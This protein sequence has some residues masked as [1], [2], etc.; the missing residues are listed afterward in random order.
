MKNTQAPLSPGI[1]SVLPLFYVAWS[2]GIL[3][4][5][6]MKTLHRRLKDFDFLSGPDRDY[7]KK[8]TDPTK[9]PS[10]EI[11]KSWVNQIRLY[12][13]DLPQGSKQD[14]VQL[15]IDMAMAAAP[16]DL[17]SRWLSQD[18]LA[19]LREIKDQLGVEAVAGAK[20]LFA[21]ADQDAEL[22]PHDPSKDSL[23]GNL[24]SFLE[25]DSRSFKD[26]LRALFS[27]PELF[28]EYQGDK[29][30]HRELVLDQMRILA[31]QGY[32]LLPYPEDCGGRDD[33]ERY[34]QVF[35][36]L[37][38]YDGSLVVK[39][40]VQFGLY[41]LSIKNLGT[42]E[43]HKKYLNDAGILK[44]LGCFA[45]TETGHGSNVRGL[46][47]TASYDRASDLIVVHTPDR[48]SAKEYIGN[49]LHGDMAV[50][51]A[52][53]IVN[54][55]NHGVHAVVVP[56]REDNGQDVQGV[57]REDCGYKMGLNG[58][59]NGRLYFDQVAVPRSNLLSRFGAISDDGEY[60]SRIENPNKRFFTMLGTLVGGRIGVAKGALSM[61]KNALTIALRY[62]ERRRQFGPA[63]DR[64][65]ALLM[66]YPSHQM[67]LLP[68][69]VKAYGLQ[70]ATDQLVEEYR[71]ST[72]SS[73]K[74]ETKAAGL[75]ACATWFATDTIQECREAC[76]GAGYIWE[77]GL[78]Q[79]KADSD[80]FTTFEG[81]NT[82]LMQLVAKGLLSEF[83]KSFHDEG[84][85]AVF[86]HLSQRVT[87]S[88]TEKNVFQVRKTDS[89][90]LLSPEFHREAFRFREKHLLR[91]VGQRMKKYLGK[92]VSLYE[93]F[94]RCQNHMIALAQAYVDRLILKSLHVARDRADGEIKELLILCAEVYALHSIYE[95][96]AYFLEHGY[97]EPTKTKAVLRVL[98]QRLKKIRPK[99]P[100]LV[101][102]WAIPE[103]C[104]RTEIS[105]KVDRG[106]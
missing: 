23:R 42:E 106:Y 87:T 47:T 72:S 62:A 25:G 53:L 1:L 65:Q 80:I 96:R 58:V 105:S 29:E 89:S 84:F 101:E 88:L 17:K 49:A 26:G 33:M 73:Q 54:D 103:A 36:M 48:A 13:K 91:T 16:A 86:R 57:K 102:A 79:I 45:M 59:D 41:G 66:D 5:S 68:R 19:A 34:L 82:V 43:Q 9:P 56:L 52:Q 67:R 50:V 8:W 63:E 44:K 71:Q 76:G 64:P 70:F 90:H 15:G 69:L 37:A 95:E 30:A 61:A 40:G 27:D 92:R 46:K 21:S 11:F 77:N 31:D 98:E 10:E 20:L 85:M 78:T 32:G 28:K 51:F 94:L 74:L 12:G 3:S 99:A 75:K 35:E 22:A 55:V 100:A 14:L 97:M 38:H 6:E 93:A 4:P 7:L 24:Q 83:K 39:Y 81:D 18:T 60:H 104:L 2:D